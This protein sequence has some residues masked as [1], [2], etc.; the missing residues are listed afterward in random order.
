MK[1]PSR[2]ILR[3]LVLATAFA[4][5]GYAPAQ[6]A[7]DALPSGGSIVNG[8]V[9]I[10]HPAAAM[11]R[12]TS[13]PGAIMNWHSF[14]IGSAASVHIDQAGAASAML[15]RVTGAD[16]SL[17][18]GRLESNGR[19]F[20]INPNG[21][22]FGAGSV[23]DVHGL[24][25]ST[26]DIANADFL[27]GNYLFEGVG[28]G[29]I[30]LMQ[31]ARITTARHADGQVWLFANQLRLD[32]GSLI[33]TPD[34]QAVLAAGTRL[35]AGSSTLGNMRFQITAGSAASIE[36]HGTLAA[37][38]GAVGMFADSITHGGALSVTGSGEVL[39]MAARDLTVLDGATV[40]ADGVAGGSGGHI[41]LDAGNRLRIAA[42]ASVSADGGQLGGDGGRI[43]LAAHDLQVSPV[44]SGMGNV[45]AAAGAA[46]ARSG[47]VRVMLRGSPADVQAAGPEIAV[48]LA[49]GSDMYPD[50]TYLADGSFVVTWMSMTAPPNVIWDVNYATVY[51]QRYSAA[52]LPLGAPIQLGTT[53]G[54]QSFPA[55]APARNGGFL[56]AWADGRSGRQEVWGRLFDM[57]GLP[58]GADLRLSQDPGDQSNVK[59]A[60]LSDGRYLLSWSSRASLSPLA[61]DVRG[62][63]LDA[64]GAPLGAAF[65]LNLTGSADKGYQYRPDIATLADGGF[66]VTW[67]ALAPNGTQAD[68]YGRRFDRNGVPVGPE[69]TIAASAGDDWRVA[70]EGLLD[71]G[72]VVV[73]DSR[74]SAGNTRLF[75]HRYDAAGT[76]QQSTVPVGAAP[77]GTGQSFAQVAALADGGFAIAW[78]SYQNGSGTSNADV[79]AQRFSAEGVPVAGPALIASGPASQWEPRIAA[80]AD[81]GYVLSWYSNQTGG[82]DVIAQRFAAAPQAATLSDGIG[83]ELSRRAYYTVPGMPNGTASPPLLLTP[84]APNTSTRT[85]SEKLKEAKTESAHNALRI[86]TSG[87]GRDT[88]PGASPIFQMEPVPTGTLSDTSGVAAQYDAAEADV[89]GERGDEQR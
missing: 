16:P 9:A 55:I 58:I 69:F 14:S 6:I 10:A 41:T 76:M 64:A 53:S 67:H 84:S 34:G 54:K 12:I 81:G 1:H 56:A 52:G 78:M 70:A 8:T 79:Y 62:Q 18:L 22:L 25:A 75:Y 29:N 19:V 66:V 57:N 86:L 15:N 7:A 83:G 20:L 42:T 24:V 48:T 37:A 50:L 59:L 71:G 11:M 72:F 3:P 32:A 68:A 13:S 40:R 49:G 26:R 2:L 73:W 21:L 88:T 30:V 39:M 74:D 31:G 77:G 23:V 46:G 82:L 33:E 27:N 45:R 5:S 47:E 17:I 4:F 43:A 80:S 87:S 35:E 89:L 65:T 44:A 85:E 63:L 51:A 61:I 28:D 60:T 38:R 36:S